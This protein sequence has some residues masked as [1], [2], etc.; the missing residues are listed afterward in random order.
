M[1]AVPTAVL[2]E[3]LAE[4]IERDN[5]R[6]AFQSYEEAAVRICD[7]LCAALKAGD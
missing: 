5:R 6:A 2:R 3:E 7:A 4:I 1:Q